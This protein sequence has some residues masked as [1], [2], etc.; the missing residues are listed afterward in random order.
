M[1]IIFLLLFLQ[2]QKEKISVPV[3]ISNVTDQILSFLLKHAALKMK[4]NHVTAWKVWIVDAGF[5]S[6]SNVSRNHLKFRVQ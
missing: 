5:P 4:N 2:S 3:S 1:A 6:C